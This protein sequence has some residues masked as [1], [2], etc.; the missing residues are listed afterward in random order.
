VT[1][2]SP[3]RAAAHENEFSSLHVRYYRRKVLHL[4]WTKAG[5]FKVVT[6]DEG[7]WEHILWEQPAPI[8]FEW[9][10]VCF[11]FW[12][13]WRSIMAPP[14]CRAISQLA[15]EQPSGRPFCASSDLGSA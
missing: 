3:F 15:D 4:R 9:L 6:F 10:C 11:L 13:L 5:D 1:L 12:I 2:L 14:S 7:D 8:P